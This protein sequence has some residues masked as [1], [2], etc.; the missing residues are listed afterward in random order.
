MKKNILF[1][2]CRVAYRVAWQYHLR[3]NS[4]QLDKILSYPKLEN[5]HIYW[6]ARKYADASLPIIWVRAPYAP[7][8]KYRLCGTFFVGM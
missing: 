3:K 1:C 5:P 7:L 8:E 2:K 6:K 4:V